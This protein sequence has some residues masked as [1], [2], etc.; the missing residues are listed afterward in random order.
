MYLATHVG[1]LLPPNRGK[2]PRE[3]SHPSVRLP[4]VSMPSSLCELLPF[5]DIK[6]GGMVK[7]RMVGC[8]SSLVV[9]GSLLMSARVLLLFFPTPSGDVIAAQVR[10]QQ[11][12]HVEQAEGKLASP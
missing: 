1:V 9:V 11:G 10:P 5:F 8:R 12:W 2:K 3:P 4:C 6:N 7:S